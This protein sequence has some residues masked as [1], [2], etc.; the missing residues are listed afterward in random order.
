MK[1]LG[2]QLLAFL[3]FA[4]SL[5]AVADEK[6][7][8]KPVETSL[9]VFTYEGKQIF[10]LSYKNAP[11]WHTYWKNPGDAGLPTE[12]K[13]E[14]FKIEE[15]PWPVPQRFIEKGDILA[16]GYGGSYTRFFT[17]KETPNDKLK[18][19]SNWLVCKHICIPGKVDIEATYAEGLLTQISP[20]DFILSNEEL[21]QRYKLLPTKE[22]WPETL[23]LVLKKGAE[24]NQLV[25]YYNY[26]NPGGKDLFLPLGLLTPYRQELLDIQREKLFKNSKGT[27]FGKMNIGWDGEYVDPVVPFP[28]GGTF[29]EPVT[30]KFLWQNPLDEKVVIIEKQ[31]TSFDVTGGEAID[32]LMGTMTFI[33]PQN[34]GSNGEEEVVRPQETIPGPVGTGFL[35]VLLFAFL[36]GLI[37]N[38]MPCVLPVISLKLF[39]LV[40]HS[41]ES[42]KSILRHNIFY[43]LGVLST[44]L[45]LSLAIIVLKSTGENVGWG[46]QLQSPVFVSLMIAVLFIFALNLFGLYEFQTPGGKVLGDVQIKKGVAGDFLGGVLATILS[47]PCSAPFLGTALT[48]AFTASTPEIIVTFQAIGLGLAF[49]FLMTGIFPSSIKFLPK[50][51]LWME[52][53]KKFL[54]LTLILT[55]LW[56]VDVFL[57]LT[58]GNLPLL[59]L[60]TGLIFVFFAFY[61][62]KNIS[63]KKSWQ[64]LFFILAIIPFYFLYSRPFQIEGKMEGA[65]DLI[66]EKNSAGKVLWEPWSEKRMEEL[67]SQGET[68]F[69]DFTAKW[70]FTCKVN[71]KLVLD[72]NSFKELVQDK[73]I[74][75]LLGD[76]TKY[77]PVI[78]AFLKKHGYV[79]VPAY[80]IQK[81]DG[82]L[83]KLGETI[84]L[85]KIKENI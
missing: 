22:P 53:V 54:G 61:F 33:K 55:A 27:L 39:G 24:D 47:T 83:I 29:N 11:H 75:L 77:D 72:T 38:I 80:F 16:Y 73:N 70:C 71:E 32:S 26:T 28:T 3:L 6:I 41:D 31:F 81:P 20:Q 78:G 46:F 2:I 84:T 69:I 9:Q 56:L 52:S 45:V 14:N 40:V 82:T 34:P 63:K 50:P 8:D 57:S 37:L 68:V 62:Q 65:G 74:K 51:G 19:S 25:A 79:G 36:G 7:P 12:I 15:Y 67:Q 43:T 10:A 44:F 58:S 59:K 1:L 5:V 35:T 18:L 66:S 17:I 21:I 85:G 42:H 4:T 49:P 76:W 30:L 13:P 23:D 48:F 64:A 60:L